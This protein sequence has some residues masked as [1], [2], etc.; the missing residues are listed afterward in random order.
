M[1]EVASF[2]VIFGVILLVSKSFLIMKSEG[3]QKVKYRSNCSCAHFM[4]VFETDVQG[5][6]ALQIF[7]RQL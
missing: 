5:A 2:G 7:S 6:I 4:A 1:V 3:E